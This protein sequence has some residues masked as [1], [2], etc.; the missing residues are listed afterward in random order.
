MPHLPKE[1]T[2]IILRTNKTKACTLKFTNEKCSSMLIT[3]FSFIDNKTYFCFI[4]LSYMGAAG[5]RQSLG[6]SQEW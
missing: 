1:D 6:N 4:N 3:A 5:R 2:G